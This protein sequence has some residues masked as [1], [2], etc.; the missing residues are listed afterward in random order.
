MLKPYIALF[1]QLLFGWGIGAN[2]EAPS[3]AP[4][5]G[6]GTPSNAAYL[7]AGL[8]IAS[9]FII[10]LFGA[11][12]GVFIARSELSKIDRGQS[13]EA[14]RIF[15]QIGWYVGLANLVLSVVGLCGGLA[16]WFGLF[17][18]IMGGAAVG[19]AGQ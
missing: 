6:S 14:G 16:L 12:G 8:S 19:A 15:A 10:P 9:W 2:Y 11:I 4:Q 7:A 3:P 13:P 1:A 5:G 17:A 18:L